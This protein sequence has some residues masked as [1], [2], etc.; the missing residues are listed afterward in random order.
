MFL[1][2]GLFSLISF[3][4]REI[5]FLP[6]WRH[7]TL[8]GQNSFKSPHLKLLLGVQKKKKWREFTLCWK[9]RN[10]F[11]CFGREKKMLPS[12]Q[13]IRF[14]FCLI[15]KTKLKSMMWNTCTKNWGAWLFFLTDSRGKNGLHAPV[16]FTR[17]I[18]LLRY[19][20]HSS[21]N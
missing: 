3:H 18:L 7:G 16:Q 13:K 21:L 8:S 15:S 19:C 12:L 4:F 11:V 14:F 2:R 10:N 9:K 20:V 5:N 1:F 17:P 6:A